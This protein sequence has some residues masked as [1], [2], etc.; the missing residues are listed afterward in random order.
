MVNF[1]AARVAKKP[2]LENMPEAKVRS[3]AGNNLAINIK[4]IGKL[5]ASKTPRA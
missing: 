3:L 1:G 5:T 4:Q 2:P